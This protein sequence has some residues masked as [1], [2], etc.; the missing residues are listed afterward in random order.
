MSIEVNQTVT[1]VTPPVSGAE[2]TALI[3]ARKELSRASVII[4]ASV[5]NRLPQLTELVAMSADK[6]P[7]LPAAVAHVVALTQYL[8]SFWIFRKP[9]IDPDVMD[10]IRRNEEIRLGIRTR[11][12]SVT[13]G[14]EEGEMFKIGRLDA[15][16]QSGSFSSQTKSQAESS[17]GS[18]GKG[19]SGQKDKKAPVKEQSELMRADDKI[20]A[21]NSLK[22]QL[23]RGEISS[24]DYAREMKALKKR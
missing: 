11:D 5:Y 7:A 23:D 24:G 2:V 21:E 10:E 4:T 20:R 17:Q 22:K 18:G 13:E 6:L 12:G 3:C 16:A 1:G 15:M 8:K 19:R 14:T 9:Q